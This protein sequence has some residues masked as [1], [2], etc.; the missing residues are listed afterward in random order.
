MKLAETIKQVPLINPISY[1]LIAFEK[2]DAFISEKQ[3]Q[4]HE[5]SQKENVSSKT[6]MI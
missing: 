1:G 3:R 2:A 4:L 5:K 6:E